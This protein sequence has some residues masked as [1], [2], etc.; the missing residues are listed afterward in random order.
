MRWRNWLRHYTTSGKVAGL[1]PDGV[2]GIFY[3][4]RTVAL[5]STQAASNINEYQEYF[6]GGKGG[7]GVGLTILPP[8]CAGCHEIWEPQPPGTLRACPDLYR[9]C[10]TF[11]K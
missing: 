8:S 5:G 9:D 1:F 6:M 4:G 11:Y 2:S 7:L 10:F 3:S